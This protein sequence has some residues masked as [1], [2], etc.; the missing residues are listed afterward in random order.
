MAA[1]D[2]SAV[3]LLDEHLARRDRLHDDINAV[4][5]VDRDTARTTAATID[6]RRARGES[7]GPLAG[8]PM[9]VKDALA[10]AGLR[11]TGGAVELRDQIPSTDAT[12]VAR[13]RDADAV[14]FGKSNLPR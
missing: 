13:T 2:I 11:T 5:T 8:L 1:G 4:V 12:V 6:N 10:T 3:E 7:L 9:S 14:I